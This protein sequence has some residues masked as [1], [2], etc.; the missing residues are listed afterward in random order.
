M[1]M[2]LQSLL[3]ALR[4]CLDERTVLIKLIRKLWISVNLEKVGKCDFWK[5]ELAIW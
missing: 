1:S 3:Q 4:G 2:K 5:D